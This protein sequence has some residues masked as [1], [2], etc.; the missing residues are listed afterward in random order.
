MIPQRTNIATNK[1]S[2]SEKRTD[3]SNSTSRKAANTA[4]RSSIYTKNRWTPEKSSNNA[5]KERVVIR[6]TQNKKRTYNRSKKS[7]EPVLSIRKQRPNPNN[8]KKV[9]RIYKKKLALLLPAHNEGLIIATTIQ[10]AI[11]A[12][13]NRRDIFVVDDN[14]SDETRRDAVK[15]LG[16]SHVLTVKR[17]G[18]ALAVKKALKKFDI[19]RKYYWVHIADA[20]SVFSPKYFKIYKKNLN[21]KKYAVAVGFVQS[22][23]GNWLS[24]YRAVTYTYSQHVNR[25]VQSYLGMISVFPGP[26]TSFRTDIIKSLE[27]G[28]D[29]F[30][31]DFDI[32]VQVHRKKLGKIKFIPK[33]INYTQDPQTLSD[34]WKQNLRWQRGFFQGVRK[35]KI[36]LKMRAIDFSIGFQMFQTGFYLLE[37]FVLI[38]FLMIATRN[39]LILPVVIAADFVLTGVIALGS[40]AIT[41]RWT[42]I[43]ALPYF[44]FLR[45][46]EIVI[47]LKAFTEIMILRKFR[48]ET[49][50]WSTAGRRY[51]LSTEA[52]KDTAH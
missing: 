20:D 35:Y 34:F 17:S 12:G 4:P 26:I 14:S 48:T 38:P 37:M 41:K 42:L 44:Y 31:E 18:K 45:W 21:E 9:S 43:G 22:M 3:F 33:A 50:G 30:T 10:S 27:F 52:L 46:I 40:S 11:A 23:R 6:I 8:R 39:W 29:S 32:T 36:G 47:F 51:K 16:K 24:T 15:L 13:Q 5:V 25:R 1:R 2:S 28:S 7:S 19:E 49:T